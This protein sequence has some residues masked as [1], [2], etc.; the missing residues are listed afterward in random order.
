MLD[1]VGV[2][3]P[4]ISEIDRS[5]VSHSYRVISELVTT[6]SRKMPDS[7]NRRMSFVRRIN[8]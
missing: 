7:A 4:M 6:M 1:C 3:T 5:S 2:S 8:G